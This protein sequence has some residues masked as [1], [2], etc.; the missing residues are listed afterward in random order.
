[1]SQISSDQIIV[2]TNGNYFARLILD[3]LFRH[4]H[5]SITGVLIV[6]GDYKARKGMRAVWEIGKITTFPYLIYKVLIMGCFALAQCRY[7]KSSFGVDR[8]ADSF[9]IAVKTVVSVN[10]HE[11]I[12]WVKR[13]NPDLLVSVSCPQ[14]IG[15]KMLAL[16]RLGGLNIHSSLLPAYAGLA[17][18]FWVLSKGEKITGTTVHYMS[19]KFDDGNTLSQKRLE[20]TPGESAF[21]LFIRLAGLGRQALLDAVEM[22]LTG[23]AGVKQDKSRY[24]YF[25]HPDFPSYVMLRRRGHCLLRIRELLAVIKREVANGSAN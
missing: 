15:R 25:S 10:S 24:T 14:M 3:D 1:M 19:L 13:R 16:G 11:A 18:Y 23:N 2:V 21:N 9:G 22:A 8:L 17:P 4:Q 20:I 5:E 6:S 12:E 7:R